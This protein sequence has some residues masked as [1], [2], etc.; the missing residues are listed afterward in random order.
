MFHNSLGANAAMMVLC[1]DLASSTSVYKV[2][3]S[4]SRRSS[5]PVLIA[6]RMVVGEPYS[7]PKLMVKW[8]G[9]RSVMR[10]LSSGRIMRLD[11]FDIFL[12]HH[13]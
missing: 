3:K 9:D 13:F 11:L 4:P 10:A 6:S 8:V 2:N 5:I 1:Q 7:A 12:T